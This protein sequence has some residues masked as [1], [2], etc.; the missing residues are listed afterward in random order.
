MNVYFKRV[1]LICKSN[2]VVFVLLG[3][4]AFHLNVRGVSDWNSGSTTSLQSQKEGNNG[5]KQENQQ[6]NSTHARPHNLVPDV[7]EAGGHAV[8]RYVRVIYCRPLNVT[9]Y[10][11]YIDFCKKRYIVQFA[12]IVTELAELTRWSSFTQF[13]C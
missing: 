9:L 13:S 12:L 5:S 7:T 6:R 11:R 2:L 3:L 4:Q 1:F 8:A 10:V